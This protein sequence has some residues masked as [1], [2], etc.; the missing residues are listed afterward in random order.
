MSAGYARVGLLGMPRVGKSTYLAALWQLIE[1]DDDHS[2]VEV[3]FTGDR[4]YLQR[5]GEDLTAAR[6]LQ[7]TDVDSEDGLSLTVRLEDAGDVSLDIPDVSGEALRLLIED[8]TWHPRLFD[9]VKSA[10]GFLLFVNVNDVHSPT[11]VDFV[12]HVMSAAGVQPRPDAT[13]NDGR[14]DGDSN[15]DDSAEVEQGSR[16]ETR[17]ACTSAKLVDALENILAVRTSDSPARLAVVISAWDAKDG[18]DTPNEWL[19]HNLPAVARWCSANADRV[20]VA[21]FGVSAQ[22]GSL[23]DQR[24]ELLDKGSVLQR[25]FA[26]NGIGKNIPLSQPLRWVLMT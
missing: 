9:L 24:Q 16:F 13:G 5:L 25:S 1:E 17:F 8:R 15:E 21:V 23:P 10:D 19:R 11:R 18:H 7:R 22:G 26:H 12:N 20:T 3:D 6:E 4:A 14:R 2:I